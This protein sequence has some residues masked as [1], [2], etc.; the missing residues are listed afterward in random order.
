MKSVQARKLPLEFILPIDGHM[1]EP[2]PKT[3]KDILR[4]LTMSKKSVEECAAAPLAEVAV[5]PGDELAI[6]TT[7]CWLLE[8]HRQSLEGLDGQCSL[9]KDIRIIQDGPDGLPDAYWNSVVYRANQKH[10]V[11]TYAKAAQRKVQE[12]IAG[13]QPRGE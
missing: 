10:I 2:L 11:R 12:I 6:Y 3:G 9:S 5:S 1:K 13:M 8:Q 7:F 4:V